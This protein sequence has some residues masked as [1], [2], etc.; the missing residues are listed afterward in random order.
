L[1]FV[2]SI[3][4]NPTAAFNP[5]PPA[6]M[7]PIVF[8]P[9]LTATAGNLP[10]T[11]TPAAGLA[12]TLAATSTK[13]PTSTPF[14]SRT[15]F[16]LPS[17]TQAL[18]LSVPTHERLPLDGQCIVTKQSP[19]DGTAFKPGTEFTTSWTLKNTSDST[20]DRG[21]VDLKFMAGEA[22]YKNTSSA[23]LPVSVDPSRSFDITVTMITPATTGYHISYW[24]LVSGKKVLCTFYVEI[25]VK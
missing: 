6:T 19:T 3:F 23:D 20:W 14:P 10:P 16:V 2:S 15:P 25:L 4:T 5:F 11:W 24:N 7:A 9:S 1:A 12:P 21:S 18:E 22:M 13:S 17:P 8:V